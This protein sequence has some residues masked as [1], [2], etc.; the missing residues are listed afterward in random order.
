MGEELNP[1]NDDKVRLR[2]YYVKLLNGNEISEE[3]MLVGRRVEE[4]R[5]LLE[6]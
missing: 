6:R 1:D 3:G 2:E 4:M 5:E